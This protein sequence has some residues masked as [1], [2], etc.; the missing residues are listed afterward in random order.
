MIVMAGSRVGGDEAT[1]PVNAVAAKYDASVL[2][3]TSKPRRL[4]PAS[5]GRMVGMPRG[6]PAVLNDPHGSDGHENKAIVQQFYD[7]QQALGESCVV[8]YRV[9]FAGDATHLPSRERLDRDRLASRQFDPSTDLCSVRLPLF[10]AV[11]GQRE[12]RRRAS[13]LEVPPH[14]L[15]QTTKSLSARSLRV[16]HVESGRA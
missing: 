6:A 13:F 7:G 12:V 10:A 11:A 8:H 14:R 5:A 1:Y 15:W 16:V 2:E 4:T 3:E 9:V